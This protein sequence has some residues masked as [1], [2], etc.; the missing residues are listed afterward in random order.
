MVSGLAA[1]I[2]RRGMYCLARIGKTR[3]VH[4]GGLRGRK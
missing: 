1:G 2:R 3:K 4:E